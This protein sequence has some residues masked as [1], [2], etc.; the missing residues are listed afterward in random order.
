MRGGMVVTGPKPVDPMLDAVYYPYFSPTPGWLRRASLCWNT[1]HRLRTRDA[2]EDPE[3]IA[4]LDAALGGVLADIGFEDA[5]EQSDRYAISDEFLNWLDADIERWRGAARVAAEHNALIGLYASKFP[6]GALIEELSN[7]GVAEVRSEPGTVRMPDWEAETFGWEAAAE[8][9]TPGSP[10]D[11]YSSL[12]LR[13]SRHRFEGRSSEADDLERHAETLRR[14]HLVTV[15]TPKY[16]I[17]LPEGIASHYVALVARQVAEQSNLDL[18]A[19][20]RQSTNVVTHSYRTLGGEVAE[21]VL[22]LHMPKDI[23]SVDP[24][25]LREVRDELG[26]RRRSFRAELD[27]FAERLV[28]DIESERDADRAV[29]DVVDRAEAEIRRVDAAYKKARLDVVGAPVGLTFAPPA[30]ATVLASLLGVGVLGPLGIG[31][32]VGLAARSALASHRA[33]RADRDAS[34][35]SYVLEA[36][37][38]LE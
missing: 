35:W 32:V 24:A 13:A 1:V 22:Q 37:A 30:I 34:P 26:P 7:R 31:A 11:R 36:G 21:S 23:D 4:E 10:E 38:R 20:Q 5:A 25:R 17:R 28:R 9:P 19:D 2:P 14:E 8:V 29:R 16:L 6:G 18:V 3:A 12:K 27:A 33:G 15:D